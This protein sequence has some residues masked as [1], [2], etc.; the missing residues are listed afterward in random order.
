[1]MPAL[2]VLDP[3]NDFFGRD[4]PKLSEFQQTVPVI[5]A[6][7][8]YFRDRGWPI[9]FVQHESPHK[10]RGTH[11]WAIYAGFDVRPSD[12]RLAKMIYNAFWHTP[13]DGLLRARAVDTVVVSGYVAE[14]CV[15]STVRGAADLG[16][17]AAILTGSIASLNDGRAAHTY[18]VA[19]TVSLEALRAGWH[20]AAAT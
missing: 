19:D 8:G 20:A 17:R 9:A 14:L 15:L 2:L 18:S 13:L 12:L 4:N 7:L 10:V 3:Q 5:N 11:A 6:A 16:Y 1:M